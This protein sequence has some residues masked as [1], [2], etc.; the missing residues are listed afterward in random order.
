MERHSC[1]AYD[2]R[3]PILEHV[4]LVVGLGS[5][6]AVVVGDPGEDLGVGDVLA[7]LEAGIA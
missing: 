5:G 1:F 6:E 7:V 4:P 2:R 3:L